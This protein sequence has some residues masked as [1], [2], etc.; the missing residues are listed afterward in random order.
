MHDWIVIDLQDWLNGCWNRACIENETLPPAIEASTTC[1]SQNSPHALNEYS[2]PSIVLKCGSP[3]AVAVDRTKQKS[4][5]KIKERD[6]NMRRINL[7]FDRA[8]MCVSV[9]ACAEIEVSPHRCQKLASGRLSQSEATTR[10]PFE[11]SIPLHSVT[12]IRF[13]S[14]RTVWSIIAADQHQ[15]RIPEWAGKAAASYRQGQ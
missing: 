11:Y 7:R 12:K 8:R 2:V 4:F 3:Y 6:A 9:C 13:E 10:S 5:T 1:S 14:D 15:W